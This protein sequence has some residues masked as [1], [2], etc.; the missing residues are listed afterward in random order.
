MS[1]IPGAYVGITL[2][3]AYRS[4]GFMSAELDFLD[5]V[6]SRLSNKTQN[7]SSALML[8][9]VLVWLHIL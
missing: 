5:S 7:S 8:P 4:A 1:V 3:N 9:L 2:L 6:P